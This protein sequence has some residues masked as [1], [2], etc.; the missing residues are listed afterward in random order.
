MTRNAVEAIGKDEVPG[1]NPGSSSNN[2]RFVAASAGEGA[3][4]GDSSARTRPIDISRIWGCTVF[5]HLSR[6][7]DDPTLFDCPLWQEYHS[8]NAEWHHHMTNT[9]RHGRN[10]RQDNCF[11]SLWQEVSRHGRLRYDPAQ[12]CPSPLLFEIIQRHP[13]SRKW[14]YRIIALR[15]LSLILQFL[16]LIQKLHSQTRQIFFRQ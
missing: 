2:N 6:G 9:Y 13:S 4:E 15:R 7:N 8:C 5:F 16:Q 12:N 3:I 10:Q 11:A 1:P 14:L